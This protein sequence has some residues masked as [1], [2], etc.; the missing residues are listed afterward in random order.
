MKTDDKTNYIEY[1]IIKD[2]VYSSFTGKTIP[3]S[4]LCSFNDN[5]NN[6][7]STFAVG[8]IVKQTPYKISYAKIASL[9]GDAYNTYDLAFTIVSIIG[10]FQGVVLVTMVDAVYDYIK[11]ELANRIIYAIENN[12]SGGI[13]VTINT[14]EIKK[15]QGGAL[16]TGYTYELEGIKV[17]K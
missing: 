6:T 13:T 2:E 7:I 5:E 8:D 16:V 17:Y 11:G 1:D 10:L 15:H 14:V 12:V 4:E 9:V 3:L